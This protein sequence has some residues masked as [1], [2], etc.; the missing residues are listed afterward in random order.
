MDKGNTGY[1]SQAF[2][3]LQ[4]QIRTLLEGSGGS[5]SIEFLDALSQLGNKE[6]EIVLGVFQKVVERI[7]KNP[8]RL[9]TNAD[10]AAKKFEDELYNDIMSAMSDAAAV[11]NISGKRLEVL[12]GGRSIKRT[13]KQNSVAR[14]RIS[15]SRRAQCEYLKPVLN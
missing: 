3:S 5:Q 1:F 2:L 15:K 6:Q 12:E 4:L 14:R 7:A 11:K 8:N 13:S 10:N 9:F